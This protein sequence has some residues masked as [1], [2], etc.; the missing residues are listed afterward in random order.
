[1]NFDTLGGRRYILT[2]AAGLAATALQWAGK[3]DA[4]GTSYAAIIM[5]TVAAYIVGNTYQKKTEAGK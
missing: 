1:M 2:W 3:L 4:A 5:G